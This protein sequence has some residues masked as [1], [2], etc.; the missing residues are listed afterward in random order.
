MKNFRFFGAVPAALA[1]VL[2]AASG[3]T[4]QIAFFQSTAGSVSERFPALSP[5]ST[6][7]DSLVFV[8]ARDGGSDLYVKAP[9]V[10]D[11]TPANR[12][13]SGLGDLRSPSWSRDG[14]RIVFERVVG[15]TSDIYL[16]DAQGGQQAFLQ[17]LT[18]G[19]NDASP[20]W[21]PVED[22]VAF[23]REVSPG[24]WAIFRI[25][26]DGSGLAQLT[27]PLPDTVVGG[28]PVVHRGSAWSPDGARI[29]FGRGGQIHSMSARTGPSG[30]PTQLTFAGLNINS[31]WSPDG[32]WIAFASNR[33]GN[34]D[35]F[36]MSSRGEGHG[37]FQVTTDPAPDFEPTWSADGQSIAFGSSRT[38][39]SNIWIASN[40]PFLQDAD[41]DLVP[42][43]VDGCPFEAP[44]PGEIDQNFDGC[45]DFFAPGFRQVRFWP[46]DRLNVSV[47]FSGVGDPRIG[48]GSE[49]TA[50]A[51]AAAT[52][53]LGVK[54]TLT[55]APLPEAPD[56]PVA[57]DGINNGAFVGPD[58]FPFGFGIIA[59]APTTFALDDTVIDGR[60]YRTG[61][62]VDSDV[63]FN[64]TYSFST[65]SFVPPNAFDVQSVATHE[66]GHILGLSHSSVESSTMFYV[67]PRGTGAGTLEGDDTI[68]MVRAY[69]IPAQLPLV[70]DIEGQVI[71]GGVDFTP[72]AGAAVL[73][74][75]VSGDTLE[76]TVSGV[77]GTYR[78]FE[79]NESFRVY[80]T[81]LDG[82]DAVNGTLPGHL[83]AILAG[84]AETT[85]LPEYWSGVSESN[86][87]FGDPG[88]I[89]DPGS[90][91]TGANIILNRDVTGP[92]VLSFNPASGATDVPVTTAITVAFDEKI[93]LASV[94]GA[95]F[96]LETLVGNIGVAGSA[97][98]LQ[99][100]T[101]LV[102]TPTQPLAYATEYTL[103]I[104]PGILDL[105]GN[106]MTDNSTIA[107]TTQVA[108]ELGV[109]SV[110]PPEAPVGAEIVIFGTGFDPVAVN[111]AVIFS[112]GIPVNPIFST[113]DRMFVTVPPGA[114]TG[115]V[116]IQVGIDVVGT[117][118]TV[119]PDR[120]V[121]VGNAA[122]A[123][124][125]GF[126]PRK[127]AV[128]P[129][130]VYVY[131]ATA[132]GVTAV[133]ALPTSAN[134]L[135][136]TPIPIPGGCSGVVTLP[137]ASRAVAVGP[138]QP[139]LRAIDTIGST[140]HSVIQDASLFGEP[141]GIAVVPG[142]NEVLI[143]YADRVVLHSAAPG[144]FGIEI[145]DWS[146]GGT[147]FLGDI[148]VAPGGDV[149]HATTSSGVAVLGLL[150]GQG[151]V[152]TLPAGTEPRETASRPG[153]STLVGVD[154]LGSLRL[155]GATGPLLHT[156]VSQGGY[157]G[158]AMSPEGSYA[159][160]A[161][162][163][164]N[165]IDIIGFQGNELTLPGDFPTGV[166]PRD[167]AV[168][169]GG[170]YVYVATSGS[171]RIEVY[172]TE[173]ATRIASVS[174][175]A[176]GAGTILTV[177][178][179]GFDPLAAN[180]V[181]RI[182]N[183]TT[184][185]L[186]VN[187]TGTVLTAVQPA[188]AV[189]GPVQVTTPAGTSNAIPYKVV[190]R[191]D[192]GNFQVAHEFFTGV[193]EVRRVAMTRDGRFLMAIHADGRISVIGADPA[194]PDFQRQIQILQAVDSGLSGPAEMA[195]TPD[196][197]K[198]YVPDSNEG[199]MAVF[200]IDALS[201]TPL[202]RTG[203]VQFPDGTAAFGFMN[204]AMAP[205]GSRLYSTT[206][207]NFL[208]EIRTSDDFMEASIPIGPGPSP[209]I[210]IHPNGRYAY[211]GDDSG[212]NGVI[213]ILDIDPQS[214]MY[215]GSAG[216]ISLPSGSP[217]PSQLLASPDGTQLFVLYLDLVAI[218]AVTRLD[219]V[220]I[221][222]AS[223][224]FHTSLGTLTSLADFGHGMAVNRSG[225]EL[226]VHNTTAMS[227]LSINLDT[228]A[229]VPGPTD[230]FF[231][232]F[233][234]MVTSLDDARLYVP[235]PTGIMTVI[236]LTP[237]SQTTP[238]SVPT[239]GVINQP[240]PPFVYRSTPLGVRSTSLAEGTPYKFETNDGG[241]FGGPDQIFFTAADAGGFAR[242]VYTAGPLVGAQQVFVKPPTAIIVVDLDILADAVS[243]PPQVLAVA[244]ANVAPSI[245]TPIVVDFSKSIDPATISPASFVLRQTGGAGLAGIFTFTDGGRRVVFQPDLPLL[246]NTSYAVELT[247]AIEDN[248]GNP[249]ANPGVS[250]FSTGAPPALVLKA[251]DAPAARVGD[252]VVLSGTGFSRVAGANQV[253]FGAVPAPVLTS[254]PGA[255]QVLVPGG[256]VTGPVTV[257]SSSLTSNALN[258]TVLVPMDPVNQVVENVAV[259]TSG[260]QIAIVPDGS[261]AYM[262]SPGGNSVVPINIPAQAAE[263]AIAVGLNP[264][265][266]VSSPD[267]GRIFVT[268]FFSNSLSIVDSDPAHPAFQTV[269]SEITLGLNPTGL[270]SHPD[271][272]SL[273]VV[274]FGDKTLMVVDTDSSSVSF[275]QL[276][277]TVSLDSITQAITI[278]PDGTRLVIGTSTGIV[279][280]SSA[281]PG[282]V[283]GTVRVDT[284]SGGQSVGVTPDGGFVVLLT[285]DGF[286]HL[287]D[288]RPGSPTENSG[289]A[290]VDTGSGGQSVGVSPDGGY[291]YVTTADGLV[292]VYQIVQ[293]GGGGGAAT[294][295]DAAAFQ[296]EFQLIDTIE[297][298]ENPVALAFDPS[299]SGLLLVV[300]AGSND[301]S[302]IST[303][304]I[305]PIEVRVDVTVNPGTLNLKSRGQTIT[306]LLEFPP[307]LHPSLVDLA[308]VRLNGVVEALLTGDAIV[309]ADEDGIPEREVRFDRQEV[310]DVL[311]EGQVVAI[312]I[313]GMIDGRLFS[314][315]DSI[316]VTRPK[317]NS[318]QAGAIVAARTSFEIRWTQSQS[319]PAHH[320]DLF[321]SRNLG[322]DWEPIGVGLPDDAV[323]AWDVPD[324]Q[325][326]DNLIMLVARD[327]ENEIIGIAG[328][329][330]PFTISSTTDVGNGGGPPSVFAFP[331]ASPNPFAGA[332]QL[333]F[334]LPDP[335]PVTIRIYGVDGSLVRTLA[336]GAEYPAG[337]H[338]I[339]WD[340]RDFRG[341]D[342]GNRVVFARIEAGAS[343]ALQKIVRLK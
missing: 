339:T 143:V 91:I 18:S 107:F 192:I 92:T 259:P 280:V 60:W 73:A 340:G 284:G 175:G 235:Q 65:P 187:P 151:I 154:G 316:R 315:M 96:V 169:P 81:P 283:N 149:A 268:N 245:T 61:E 170:R 5:A 200:A 52:W 220:D 1:A 212:L 196:G 106:P 232:A 20:E 174:P 94:S 80:V 62:I 111:N 193:A 47:G 30:P 335:R 324:A 38:G 255:I 241:N 177:A 223:A 296:F 142:G 265:G 43:S 286:L 37:L 165:R 179:A 34:F 301:V 236:D 3:A 246:Y 28:T 145:R 54:T 21:S 7:F 227:L 128:R 98:L 207:F 330:E 328:L 242:A 116:L 139:R 343:V 110:S 188:A 201:T 257:V 148:S 26:T 254:D 14:S 158:L 256:A 120:P 44:L 135:S 274:N 72:V 204:A 9:N 56:L 162:F 157:T 113:P 99:A 66:L 109:D 299:G 313:T 159:F 161:N 228:G 289:T 88:T 185:A 224:T 131:V 42:D 168:G 314:G 216:N 209:A 183:A 123:A 137:D 178:G 320:V 17:P 342:A 198:M 36:V 298:G 221:D 288:I 249:L 33:T 253:F 262:T 247:A 234:G 86:S 147:V 260:Q 152:T 93:D 237:P 83:N 326:D 239:T 258:F 114:I 51:A 327:D 100:G 16:V 208:A 23:A 126:D 332:T 25:N 171:D 294:T 202:S 233:R 303:S 189:S 121:P 173:G 184:P 74:V 85:F 195:I 95:T 229:F 322:A 285:T 156:L 180:N 325:G 276:R 290:R 295:R 45:P 119:L 197:R 206:N 71:H 252:P 277:A 101:L 132:G 136:L 205:D 63:V 19:F 24:N 144:S 129:D 281:D 108:P 11:V 329:D 291:V 181:V 32:R 182:G 172:D 282:D 210:A 321:W 68:T 53:N 248:D 203:E 125:L 67:V 287:I 341:E 57:G 13:T 271:G 240:L 153:A 39:V 133:D 318:P 103:T 214:P 79:K 59:V 104:G 251:I 308:T 160:A 117:F 304:A 279:I 300:N 155:Y 46:E 333:R 211:A 12:L 130:G 302:F 186:T 31:A 115:S 2:I 191:P 84:V 215:R 250:G 261:R 70:H 222:P 219:M 112:P 76:M 306:A 269:V 134:F 218:T 150:P 337:R 267:G 64:T 278:T 231:D 190:N 55:A 163:I 166:D 243:V 27:A 82:S 176:G 97:S 40:L 8:S 146:Q 334:D 199:T 305:D 10:P 272:R 105:S 273:Y 77:D 307:F 102:F 58:Q 292:L 311:P 87:D 167:V 49:F 15:A 238:V 275:N 263:P 194:R 29:T 69:P 317:L 48:D 127:L 138:T 164:Q 35:I 140:L 141:L 226:L 266:V 230:S 331:P 336:E 217:A 244:P 338:V 319:G 264:F 293:L 41:G 22:A 90:G 312:T 270:V 309:D 310:I 297:V 6:G 89:V 118:F 78:F 225:T 75:G 323:E 50:L 122:G 213:R 4:A 124:S